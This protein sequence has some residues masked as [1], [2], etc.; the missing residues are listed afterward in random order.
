MHAHRAIQDTLLTVNLSLSM[1]FFGSLFALDEKDGK[2]FI[3]SCCTSRCQIYM[4]K[5]LFTLTV[6]VPVAECVYPFP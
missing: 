6:K 3:K 4:Q 2:A 1:S 5:G